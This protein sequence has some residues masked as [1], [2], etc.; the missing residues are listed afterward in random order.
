MEGRLQHPLKII[1][2]F[3]SETGEVLEAILG[4]LWCYGDRWKLENYSENRNV[5]RAAQILCESVGSGACGD[6]NAAS[7][8]AVLCWQTMHQIALDGRTC[9]VAERVSRMRVPFSKKTPAGTAKE[10]GVTSRVV[11][12]E[13]DLSGR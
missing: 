12:P 2:N 10:L 13:A 4:Q 11:R 5:G 9:K 8:T 7:A 6:A 3:H 1:D